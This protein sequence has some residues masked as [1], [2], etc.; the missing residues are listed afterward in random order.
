MNPTHQPDF[1]FMRPRLSRWV[2]F[3]AGSG[4]SAVAPGTVGT[5]LAWGIWLVALEGLTA[6]QQGVIIAVGVWIGIW[7]CSRTADD[8][9]VADHGA[10]VWDEI[11]AFWLVLWLTPAGFGWQFSAFL[12]FRFFDVV[13]PPPI[14]WVD[15]QVSGGW[16]VMADDLLAACFSL[17][18]LALGKGILV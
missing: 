16:G 8:L 14:R 10:I 7:A 13:K 18:V 9:G 5:L 2:A 12:L 11:I 4:L 3:G 1:A 6:W 15:R 17:L